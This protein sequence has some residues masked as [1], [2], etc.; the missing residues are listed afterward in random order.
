MKILKRSLISIFILLIVTFFVL[1]Y[2]LSGIVKKGIEIAAPDILGV[3]VAVESIDISIINGSAIVS[4]LA[5]GNPPAFK[6]KDAL[7]L[8]EVNIKL[9]PLSLIS[10]TVIIE[11]IKI[12]DPIINYEIGLEGTNISAIQKNISSHNRSLNKDESIKT[13]NPNTE[14]SS[15]KV[16]IDNIII[17]GAQVSAG[18]DIINEKV[19]LPE[20]KLKNIGRE[21]KPVS[22]VMAI[23]KVVSALIKSVANADLSSIYS[24][25]KGGEKA[26]TD[27]IKGIGNKIKDIF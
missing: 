23:K 5:I 10:D 2:S 12:I 22:I 11:D 1:T 14:K 8:K 15:K 17:S 16:I 19:S 9:E 24:K 27:E 7:Y 3:D 20:I 6:A 13:E 25:L 4:G 26:I 18:I 21:G